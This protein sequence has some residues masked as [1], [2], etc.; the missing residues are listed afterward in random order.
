MLRSIL[1]LLAFTSFAHAD[2]WPSWRG[3][4]GDGHSKE[5]NLPVKWDAKSVLWKVPLPGEGQSSPTIWGDR[6]FLTTALEKGKDR[7]VLCVD[8]GSGKILWQHKAWSG[9]PEPVHAM[10]GWASSTCVTDGQR[11]VAFFGKGGLHAYTVEGKPLWSRDLGEFA[12]PWGTSASPIIVGDMVIQN[13]DA[14]ENPS[15]VAL[16]LYDGKT[17]WQTPRAVPERGGWS[18]PVLVTVGDRQEVVVNGETSVRSYDPSTGKELWTCKSF[19]KRGE[20]TVTPYRGLI[21]VINGQP[22][23]IYAIRPGGKGD[24][25]ASHLAWH[26]PRKGARDQASPILV[27]KYL[28]AFDMKGTATCYDNESGKELWKERL[29]GTFVS[30]PIAANGLV[31]A[32]TEGGVTMVVEPGPRLKLIAAN[33]LD[34]PESELFRAALVPADGRFYS[35]SRTHLYAI[36]K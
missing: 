31:Y 13:C 19:A 5:T 25:T 10:N 24:V 14:T 20:P 21:Y 18:T 1:G 3:P 22:G 12:G 36:G 16:N 4:T 6:I 27:G 23:D 28:L 2:N 11:V 17:I 7:I 30:S 34:A 26:T 15:I 9:T 32:Q 35:R 29:S 8:R 33:S